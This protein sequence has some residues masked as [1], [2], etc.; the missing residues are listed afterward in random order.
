MSNASAGQSGSA[1]NLGDRN[2]AGRFSKHPRGLKYL[3]LAETWER[4]SFSGMQ[5]LLVLYLGRELLLPGHVENVLGFGSFHAA[6]SSVFGDRLSSAGLA[7]VI[8]GIYSG[9]VWLTP[10]VGA[11]LADRV[12]GRT[13]T[14][15]MGA[16]FLLAGH[17]LMAFDATFLIAL[18]C[19]VFGAGCFKTNIAAQVGDLY[20]GNDASRASGFQLYMIGISTAVIV[21]PLVCGTLG[22]R[23]SFHWGFGVAGLGMLIGLAVYLSGLRF[24]PRSVQATPGTKPQLSQLQDGDGLRITALLMLL[25]GLAL[26]SVGNEQM[27]NA[28][29]TWAASNLDLVIFGRTMPVT[30]LI[31]IDAVIAVVAMAGVVLFWRWWAKKHQDPDEITKLQVGAVI[32]LFAPVFLVVA[33]MRQELTGHRIGLVWAFMFHIFNEI[34]IAN[35]FPVSLALFSRV[36]PK[37]IGSIMIAVMY[38]NHFASNLLVGWLGTLF[39]SMSAKAFWALH[40]GLIG[41][42]FLMLMLVVMTFR[43]VL[44]PPVRPRPA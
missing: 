4:F 19:L 9:G 41:A 16:C 37:S 26:V 44:S 6:I 17:F 22:E 35:V 2:V 8:F 27:F 13:R 31:S 1:G 39:E 36:S 10:L 24:Y 7:S 21:A 40:V 38:F 33:S 34:G 43:S 42:G 28:Y 18:A 30:W 20:V 11:L 23:A 5:T 3:S 32:C 12:L 15:I 14:I 29:I 25:P